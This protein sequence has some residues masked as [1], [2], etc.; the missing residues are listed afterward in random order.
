MFLNNIESSGHDV[1]QSNY[2][3]LC[4]PLLGPSE[5]YT[6]YIYVHVERCSPGPICVILQRNALADRGRL[7]IAPEMRG[8]VLIASN[9]GGSLARLTLRSDVIMLNHRRQLH[10]HLH[11]QQRQRLRRQQVLQEL[12]LPVPGFP[13]CSQVLPQGRQQEEQI[14]DRRQLPEPGRALSPRR[15]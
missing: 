12:L 2:G 13:R 15:C 7:P 9:S 11:Q 1:N 5:I 8:N 3:L 6:K 4:A 14:A 10:H